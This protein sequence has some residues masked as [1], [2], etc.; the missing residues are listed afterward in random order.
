LPGTD[1]ALDDGDTVTYSWD[2]HVRLELDHDERIEAVAA[3]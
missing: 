2:A 3:V 1:V